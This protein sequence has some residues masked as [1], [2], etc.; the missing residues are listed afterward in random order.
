MTTSRQF[1]V[2]RYITSSQ[3]VPEGF[4][5]PMWAILCADSEDDS[6]NGVTYRFEGIYSREQLLEIF[7][8]KAFLWLDQAQEMM[9]ADADGLPEKSSYPRQT[10]VGPLA[11]WVC[12]AVQDHAEDSQQTPS[13]A[14][15]APPS[16]MFP[17]GKGPI[18]A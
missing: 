9:L 4:L 1:V 17:L 13:E 14:L 8:D 3:T 11:Q 2:H 6:E 7:R 15:E 5:V 10:V 12:A 16:T 18:L